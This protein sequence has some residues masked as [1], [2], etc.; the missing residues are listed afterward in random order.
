[1]TPYSAALQSLVSTTTSSFYYYYYHY[2]FYYKYYSLRDHHG[3][4]DDVTVPAACLRS[5]RPSS[6][7]TVRDCPDQRLHHGGGQGRE[8]H[9]VRLWPPACPGGWLPSCSSCSSCYSCSSC[10]SCSS[11]S[12]LLTSVQVCPARHG[13][14]LDYPKL[15]VASAAT[16]AEKWDA[17]LQVVATSGVTTT[18]TNGHIPGKSD[19]PPTKNSEDD[20][21]AS[22]SE[23]VAKL[24][25]HLA[26]LTEGAVQVTLILL[27][28]VPTSRCQEGAVERLVAV[29]GGLALIRNRLWHYNEVAGTGPGSCIC[30]PG[31]GAGHQGWS[32]AFPGAVQGGGR[33]S[34][35]S[36]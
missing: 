7:G 32:Q 18:W 19:Q 2:Y 34:R 15:V 16:V 14:P 36:L 6:Q 27:P 35:G 12:G 31:A 4:Q 21:F 13:G 30:P 17:C 10:S 5:P 3:P 28:P 22:V 23:S 25:L 11:T 20:F 9:G 1:M 29:A 33:A 26:W 24:L 8:G